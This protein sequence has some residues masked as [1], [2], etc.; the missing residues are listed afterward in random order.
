[1]SHLITLVKLI[2][3]SEVSAISG[4]SSRLSPIHTE[5]RENSEDKFCRRYII[6]IR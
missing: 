6:P 2:V 1:M 5:Q 4:R 3:M